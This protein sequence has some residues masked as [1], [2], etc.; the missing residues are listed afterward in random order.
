MSVREAAA[1]EAWRVAALFALRL[2][3][4]A[5]WAVALAALLL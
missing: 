3:F 2:A 5:L 4:V 1:R